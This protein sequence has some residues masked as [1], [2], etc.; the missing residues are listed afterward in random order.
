MAAYASAKSAVA[1]L[2]EATAQE[3]K[4]RAIRAN[5]VLPGT[6][7]TPQNR[8]DMPDADPAAWTSPQAIAETILFLCAPQSRAINGAAIPVTNPGV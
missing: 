6:I 8:R 4:P 3:M 5:L 7:D 2:I 1:R